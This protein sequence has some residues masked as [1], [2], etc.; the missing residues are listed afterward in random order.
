MVVVNVAIMSTFVADEVVDMMVG[1]WQLG[2]NKAHPSVD[3]ILDNEDAV[4]DS[5]DDG[6]GGDV[7]DRCRLLVSFHASSTKS[8]HFLVRFI[9][10]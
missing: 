8:K 9:V 10:Q 2:L 7:L 5:A 3:Q 6:H 4:T 1:D